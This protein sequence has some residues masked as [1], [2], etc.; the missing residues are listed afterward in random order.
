MAVVCD[1]LIKAEL[2]GF[3]LPDTEDRAV[4]IVVV[5]DLKQNYEAVYDLVVE[6]LVEETDSE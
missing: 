3:E 2:E 5:P 6:S 1:G 4:V